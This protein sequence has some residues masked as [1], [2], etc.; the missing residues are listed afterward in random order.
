MK[1][2]KDFRPRVISRNFLSKSTS[3]FCYYRY[4]QSSLPSDN[5]ASVADGLSIIFRREPRKTIRKKPPSARDSNWG[6]AH[7]TMKLCSLEI[8]VDGVIMLSS[9]LRHCTILR[10]CT[11]LKEG[12]IMGRN[13]NGKSHH[14]DPFEKYR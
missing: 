13:D 11:Y 14:T 12:R 9:P 3:P 5:E 2:S 10:F 7:S 8:W 1:R 4:W 6:N